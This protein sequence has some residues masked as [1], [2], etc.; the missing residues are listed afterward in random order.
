MTYT[1][2]NL[3]RWTITALF[4]VAL[5]FL[6]RRLSS[7]L[8]PFCISLLVAYQMVPLVNFFQYK[9]RLKNRV[10]S[11]IVTLLVVVGVLIGAILIVMP[12]IGR[13]L[14]LLSAYIQEFV[15][16]FNASEWLSPQVEDYLQN[17]IASMD[18]NMLLKSEDVRA[19]VQKIAPTLWNWVSGGMNMLSG[20]LVV[21]VCLM[22][23]FFILL[24]HEQISESWPGL[25]P[26]RYR[27]NAQMLMTDFEDN[28]SAYFRGQA[29]IAA[30][31]GILF[32]V[33]F[34]IIGLPMGIVMGLIIGALNFV[35]YM[36]VIGI[37]FCILLG[38]LQ[39]VETGRPMW[40]VMLC[41]A[42]VFVV[43]QTTQDLVLT[44]KIMGNVTGMNPALM[45]L[46]LSIW[47]SLLGIIGMIIA[48]PVTTLMVSYYKRFILKDE[49]RQQNE[50]SNSDQPP[51]TSDSLR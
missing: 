22:Y 9:C 41:I 24:D 5:F 4:L 1:K 20:L 18:V 16:N 45:L 15:V 44:P 30:I 27:A 28:M 7:V 23:I 6:V 42:A 36:Q 46:T 25:I 29:S 32:A 2:D 38:I 35:P 13:E 17:A 19:A 8:L 3:I 10:V 43:V 51:T 48:L 39:S 40:A 34:Q 26:V 50:E 21:F 14:V 11:V 49:E 37:P 47:G 33:G 31:V 12:M